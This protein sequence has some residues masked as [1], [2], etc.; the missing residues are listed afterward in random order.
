MRKR[1]G[2]LGIIA[3][4]ALI[5]FLMTACGDGGGGG[6]DTIIIYNAPPATLVGTWYTVSSDSRAFE[7]KTLGTVGA[8]ITSGGSVYKMSVFGNT[9][10]LENGSVG[11]FDY[12]INSSG[13]LN[14]SNASGTIATTIYSSGPYTKTL[15]PSAPYGLYASAN[16]SSS[17]YLSWDSVSLATGYK[18]YR[19]SS[20]SGTY[21]YIGSTY[22]T[23]STSYTDSGLSAG[24][25]YYYKVS[26]YN[27]SGSESI[28]S[29]YASATT[30]S[31]GSGS[32]FVAPSNVYAVSQSSSSI[33]ICWDSVSNASYYK[34]YRST[35]PSSTYSYIADVYMTYYLNTGLSS[36]TTYYYKVSAV[37]YYGTESNLSSYDYA[38]TSSSS[39]SISAPTGVSAS[40]ISSSSIYISWNSVS[41]AT[42]YEVYRSTSSSGTYS[43]VDYTYDTYYTDTGLSSNT[44]YY[45]RVIAVNYDDVESDYSSYASATTLS[46]LEY[47]YGIPL[48]NNTW[49]T[50]TISS[51]GTQ[52]YSFY[53]TA[54]TTYYIYWN[55][56][57]EGDGT[58]T[59]DVKVSAYYDSITGTGIFY[60]IDSGYNSPQSFTPITSRYIYLK[61]TPYNSSSSGSGTYAIKY[62]TY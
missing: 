62:S 15:I 27:S 31:S 34:L 54:G 13:I 60:D 37:N 55:D 20:S 46:S 32:S 7:I 21:T 9:V 47:E 40:A 8:L 58:K 3:L 41:S 22:T 16:S 12:S 50:N 28:M 24:T 57:Y 61:V 5:G 35:S 53:A 6:N 19:S 17:I 2:L 44:T 29:S 25:T 49:Y 39:S 14:I 26:A 30:S 11:V 59:V 18:I 43:Y 42:F 33:Y 38:T 45:Y 23:Y 4:V 56:S 10:M 1:S 48:S 51:S 52:Y 36:N